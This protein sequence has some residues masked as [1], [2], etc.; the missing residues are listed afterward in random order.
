M[1][2]T[3]QSHW[4][5]IL[6]VFFSLIL[7]LFL[8]YLKSIKPGLLD[9]ES[10][11]LF[12]SMLPV[13]IV[14]LTGGYIYKF[15]GFGIEIETSLKKPLEDTIQLKAEKSMIGE[16]GEPKATITKLKNMTKEKKEGI[17]RLSFKHHYQYYDSYAVK[18]YLKELS[19]VEYIELLGNDSKFIGVMLADDLRGKED[20][21]VDFLKRGTVLVQFGHF[22]VTNSIDENTSAIEALALVRRSSKNFFPLLDKQGN[23]KGIVTDAALEKRIADEVLQASK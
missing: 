17:E 2:P 6:S 15:K 11:W 21:F 3:I 19:N 18:E 22:M 23:M 12:I 10:K 8:I 16:I 9:I 4:S 5:L 13:L 20:E 1:L 14:L 7:I